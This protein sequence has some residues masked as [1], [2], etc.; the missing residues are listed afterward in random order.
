MWH[1]RM[2]YKLMQGFMETTDFSLISRKMIILTPFLSS[3]EYRF[4]YLLVT[5]EFLQQEIKL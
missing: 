5:F 2:F 3:Q 4:P 1:N